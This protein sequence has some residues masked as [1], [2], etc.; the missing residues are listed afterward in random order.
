MTI[1]RRGIYAANA[2]KPEKALAFQSI[3]NFER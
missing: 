2:K 1:E 3:I